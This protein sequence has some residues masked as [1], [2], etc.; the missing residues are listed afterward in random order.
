MRP[1]QSTTDPDARLYRK[2]DGQPARLVYAGHRLM[3]HQ[4]G[5]IVAARVTPALQRWRTRCRAAAGGGRA[6]RADQRSGWT[7]ATMIRVR[8]DAAGDDRDP[9][10]GAKHDRPPQRH[11]S[12]HRSPPGLRGQSAD[13]QIG[14]ARLRLAENGGRA[15]EAAA[16]WGPLVDWVF[17]FSAAIYNIVRSRRLL[18][19]RHERDTTQV[20]RVRFECH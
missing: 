12:A 5:L 16:S 10:R 8:R 11:R 2:A 9:A 14:R 20:F 13:T 3:E 18:R 17:T 15:A 6:W 1:H 19:Q 4:F 7:R